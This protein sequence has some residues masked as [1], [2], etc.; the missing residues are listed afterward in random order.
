MFIPKVTYQLRQTSPVFYTYITISSAQHR[1]RHVSAHHVTSAQT[2][3]ATKLDALSSYNTLLEMDFEPEYSFE[4]VGR[5]PSYT[6][7]PTC[8]RPRI[9]LNP[10][11]PCQQCLARQDVRRHIPSLPPERFRCSKCKC[12]R[13]IQDYP[14][15]DS[16]RALSC[17]ACHVQR[18]DQYREQK[19]EEISQEGRAR[20][21]TRAQR[22][23]EKAL[24][25]RLRKEQAIDRRER[26][27]EQGQKF[28]EPQAVQ[29]Y[30]QREQESRERRERYQEGR[31]G[32]QGVQEDWEGLQGDQED[33]D[34]W[35]GEQE[36]RQGTEEQEQEQYCSSCTQKKPLLDFGRFLTCTAC[37]RR[38]TKAKQG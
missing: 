13:L 19:G 18:R 24:K 16:F 31:E 8:Q 2:Q 33:C 15:K 37:R 3:S 7:C 21:F 32:P 36:G 30:W 29:E 17:C 26:Q 28:W 14:F 20:R 6:E 1:H 23:V 11:T 25:A 10:D 27:R 22:V 38:N 9:T 34:N 12:F 35:Q 5:V 4:P